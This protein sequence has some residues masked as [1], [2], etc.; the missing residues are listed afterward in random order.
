MVA[1]VV[2]RQSGRDRVVGGDGVGL[3]D[4]QRRHALRIRVAFR[5]RRAGVFRADADV[6]GPEEGTKPRQILLS[7]AQFENYLEENG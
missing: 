3:A 1:C 2:R 7:I 6:V 4:H 5:H